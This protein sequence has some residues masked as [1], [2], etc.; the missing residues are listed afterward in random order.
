M[1][2]YEQSIQSSGVIPCYSIVEAVGR[3]GT[4]ENS[5]ILIVSCPTVIKRLHGVLQGLR[6]CYSTVH[7]VV[8]AAPTVLCLYARSV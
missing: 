6:Y 5:S 1:K 7:T 3:G 2:R 8:N 4:G